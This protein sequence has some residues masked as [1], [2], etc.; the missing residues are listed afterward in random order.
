MPQTATLSPAEDRARRV[1]SDL[2]ALPPPE[3]AQHFQA[4]MEKGE[5]S[6]D[7]AQAASGLLR[8]ATP[9]APLNNPGNIKAPNGKFL[10]FDDPDKGWAHLRSDLQAKIEGRTKWGLHSDSS[11]LDLARVWAPA[12]ENKPEDWARNV[13]NF[14]GVPVTEKIGKFKD[15]VQPLAEAVSYAEGTFRSLQPPNKRLDLGLMQAPAKEAGTPAPPVEPR[16]FGSELLRRTINPRGEKVEFS[17]G[18]IPFS[19]LAPES[20]PGEDAFTAGLKGTATE[21]LKLLEDLTS[22]GNLLGMVTIG[23]AAGLVG[24]AAVSRPAL[25]AATRMAR[26]GLDLVFGGMGLERAGANAKQAYEL[27]KKGDYEGT[28]KKLGGMLPDAALTALSV[29]D[30]AR[31]ARMPKS[32]ALQEFDQRVRRE[33][34]DEYAA[35]RDL[36]KRS[37]GLA[38]GQKPSTHAQ[39]YAGHLADIG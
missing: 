19:T 38:L 21:G 28:T 33:F 11:I 24:K 37:P 31:L 30:A 22:P 39:V 36:E 23:G 3:R 29:L 9:T 34:I 13:S 27:Y 2:Q 26:Y 4:L 35:I 7:V 18:L 20:K 17:E 14:L 10:D 1:I 8:T 32:Q 15:N 16:S 12:S 25:Q 5:L 6:Q